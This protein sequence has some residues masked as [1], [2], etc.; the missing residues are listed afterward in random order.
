MNI[1]LDLDLSTFG[2]EGSLYLKENFDAVH[3]KAYGFCIPAS[4]ELVN[5]RVIIEEEK[6]TFPL[7][8]LEE[9]DSIQPEESAQDG[10][11]TIAYLQQEIRGCPIWRRAGLYAGHALQGPC[12]IVE[13]DSTTVILPGFEAAIDT[14]GNI[15]IQRED[16]TP[17]AGIEVVEQSSKFG[18]LDPVELDIF[19]SGLKNARFE[20]DALVTRAAMSPAIREQQ[21]EL[22]MIAEGG[23]LMIAGQFGSFIQEFLNSWKGS[24]ESG[25]VFITNDPYSVGGAVSHLND[26]LLIMPVYAGE[27]LI[28]WTAN[29][30]HLTDVGGSVP[31]SLPNGV[32]SIFEDGIQIPPTKWVSAGEMNEEVREMILRNCRLPDWNRWYV[33]ICALIAESV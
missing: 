18:T 15:L 16:S 31:G 2:Q 25:D 10:T 22:P 9:A 4:L 30:G 19:E 27:K 29:L 3:E 7:P 12:L 24:V 23:G 1:S 6:A 26:W 32:T 21:D 33:C 11:T 13:L 17:N 8:Q 28:G 14:Y 20:M 5:I